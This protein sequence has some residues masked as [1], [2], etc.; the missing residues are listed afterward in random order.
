MK[1]EL[2]SWTKDPIKTIAK[3]AS[4]C[5]RSN[6]NIKIVKSCIDSGHHSIL[7]FANFV[8]KISD[9][10]RATANQ[11][12]RHRIASY[13][14][15][16]QRY[17]DM[18]DVNFIRPETKSWHEDTLYSSALSMAKSSYTTLLE[19]GIKKEDARAVLPNACP[20][21]IC[22]SMNLRSLAHFMNERLCSCAQKPIQNMAIA[23]KKEFKNKQVD[24]KLTDDEIDLI[25]KL[26]VPKCE[27][28][29]IKYCSERK[30]CGRQKS[31]KEI[32]EIIKR[33]E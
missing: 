4:T 25:L 7:E 9:I 12:V 13:A 32:N 10:D 30:G 6:P 23:M 15:E 20:T 17:V 21:T 2:I 11:L 22:I 1:V 8:F 24:M 18:S 19:L 26:C 28:G 5:Y 27:L 33:K 29:K 31:A 3:A 16:S 14:Q